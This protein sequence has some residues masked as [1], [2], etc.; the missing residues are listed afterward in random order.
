M[1][2]LKMLSYLRTERSQID[3]AILA[4]ER[5]AAGRGKRRGRPPKWMSQIRDQQESRTKAPK[6]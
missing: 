3:D 5:F 2:I 1:D 6:K 4:L